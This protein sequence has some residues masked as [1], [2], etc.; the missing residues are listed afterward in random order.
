MSPTSQ[1]E[2]SGLNN[3]KRK[4][5]SDHDD[6]QDIKCLLGKFLAVLRRES[7]LSAVDKDEWDDLVSSVSK[8]PELFSVSLPGIF[9]GPVS[10]C[11]FD[12]TGRHWSPS[13]RRRPSSENC[14]GQSRPWPSAKTCSRPPMPGMP[15][16]MKQQG[17][18]RTVICGEASKSTSLWRHVLNLSVWT[19]L[20]LTTVVE[21][22]I[23]PD[24]N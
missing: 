17:A 15:S 18:C 1:S 6:V 16:T 10:D 12:R 21:R 22:N 19:H 13:P 23:I 5:V 4:R 2:C 3:G 7:L 24:S 8:T 11:D 9:S 14:A 20:L